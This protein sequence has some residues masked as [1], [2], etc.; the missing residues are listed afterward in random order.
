MFYHQHN[1]HDKKRK[2][3]NSN[4]K[5]NMIII[6]IVHQH[7]KYWVSIG[8]RKLSPRKVVPFS[9]SCGYVKGTSPKLKTIFS[10]WMKLVLSL[11]S[12]L[13]W[14]FTWAFVMAGWL[15]SPSSTPKNGRLAPSDAPADLVAWTYRTTLQTLKRQSLHKRRKNSFYYQQIFQLSDI[16]KWSVQKVIFS[17][18]RPHLSHA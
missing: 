18:C 9:S 17:S 12:Q 10:C 5:I 7:F 3:S 6:N 11:R 2:K 4:N 13:H 14:S 16:H 1:H 15:K 8:L